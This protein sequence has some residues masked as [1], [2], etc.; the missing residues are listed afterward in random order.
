MAISII[1]GKPGSGKSYYAVSKIADYMCDW[2]RFEEQN[3]EKFQRVLYTN[4]LL[5]VEAIEIYVKVKTGIEFDAAEH[6]E[7]VGNDFFYRESA[8]GQ[9]EPFEWWGEIPNGALVVIDEVHQYIPAGGVGKKNYMQLFTEYIA[10][11]RHREQDMILITQHTD[12]IHKNILCMAEGAYHIINVKSK[13]FPFLNIPFA[14]FDV[15]K[16]A[17]G[18]KR[19]IA[20]VLYGNYIGKSFK[21]QSQY[22]IVL[23]PAIYALYKSHMLSKGGEQTDRPSL[24]LSR[25]GAIM[26]FARKHAWHLGLKVF[27][28]L[29]VF[30]TIYYV[31]AFAPSHLSKTLVKGGSFVK[32]DT[33]ESAKIEKPVKPAKPATSVI[34]PSPVPLKSYS[35]DSDDEFEREKAWYKSNYI[36]VY[37][38]DYIITDVGRVE[39]GGE[40]ERGGKKFKLLSVNARDKVVDVQSILSLDWVPVYNPNAGLEPTGLSDD[41]GGF[42][43]N[44][45]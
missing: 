40:F 44:G 35:D 19:Q 10:T 20:N 2:A 26:W 8:D 16:E 22:T 18:C 1:I 29:S 15:I 23:S 38:K 7:L 33:P 5:D 31:L 32:L 4:L 11:H 41:A 21:Q 30:A 3:C 36:Y 43:T 17:F 34:S 42:T 6:I 28:V 45:D 39:I 27:C 24:K 37:G 25:I 9:R 12:T 14:D 13:T